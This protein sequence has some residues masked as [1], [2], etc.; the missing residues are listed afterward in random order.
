MDKAR[1]RAVLDAVVNDGKPFTAEENL[2]SLLEVRDWRKA[3]S[4]EHARLDQLIRRVRRELR[5]G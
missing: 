1:R 5:S 4:E 3:H 2:A